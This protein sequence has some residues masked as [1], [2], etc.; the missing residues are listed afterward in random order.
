MIAKST[1]AKKYGVDLLL[2][3]LIEDLKHLESVGLSFT[4]RKQDLCFTGSTALVIS[5]NLAAYW[6]R[7]FQ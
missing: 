6:L 5:D 1:D 4:F 7:G 2:V 3:P